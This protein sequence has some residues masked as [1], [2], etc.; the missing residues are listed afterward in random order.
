MIQF[1]KQDV[2]FAGG[3]EE[4]DWTMTVQFDAKPEF[5]NP[6]GNIQG[7]FLAAMLDSTL[8]PALAS[9][10][11]SEQMCP[12]APWASLNRE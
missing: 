6:M 7:G 2:M 1:G 11:T 4:V 8:S 10:L 12:C 5:L 9:T 3:G